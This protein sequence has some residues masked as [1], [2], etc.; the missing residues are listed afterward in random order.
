MIGAHTK[1]AAV[2]GD[3][4]AH[5]MSPAIHNAAFEACG[6]DW[7][8]VA[9]QVA[10][11][12]IGRAM[13]GMRALGIRGLSV[14]IPH[15]VSIIGHLDELD[16]LARWVGSVNTVVN[17]DG[18]LIGTTTDGQGALEAFRAAGETTRGRRVVILG[19][20]GAARAIAFAVARDATPSHLIILGIDEAERDR[21]GTELSHKTGI[22]VDRGGLD[23]L[24]EALHEAQV[25]I[26]PTPVGMHP[27]SDE[28]L[29]PARLLHAG[30]VVFDAVYNPP[31]TRLLSDAVRS[32][33]KAIRGV[34]M[35]VHQ[36]AAQFRLW[37]GKPPPVDV[38]E[39]VVL[40]RLTQVDTR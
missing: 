39:K 9:F 32:G 36:A 17:H 4:V 24:D 28:S 11:D 31:E 19:S 8:Y 26:Q 10:P 35:F 34:G 5:S 21:L 29:V 33:A 15:K 12:E 2:I 37:T 1:V 13:A 7:I 20:G 38:M 16:E 3:P 22:S 14:T 40:D 25:L 27:R 23:R 30:L 18:Q 6:L